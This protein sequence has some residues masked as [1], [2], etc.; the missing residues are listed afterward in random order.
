DGLDNNCDG[1]IDNGITCMCIHGDTRTCGS[2]TET[3]ECKLG[4]STCSLGQWGECENEIMPGTE[5]C[6]GLDNDCDGEV[7]EECTSDV[8]S[9][10]PIPSEG[11]LCG[12]ERKTSGFCCSGA[13][14]ENGC[15]FAWSILI[16]AGVIILI[17]LYILVYYFSTKGQELTWN[18]I[19]NKYGS[20]LKMRSVL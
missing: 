3:G 1:L 20:Y 14:F 12:S 17:I 10:G 2:S 7:D 9:E 13:Y 4:V 16:L 18:T 19:K 11:C 5:L 8:C 6:D 15:P